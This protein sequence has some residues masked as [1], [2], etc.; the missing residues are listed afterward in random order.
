MISDLLQSLFTGLGLGALYSIVGIGFV[1]IYRVTGVANLTQG[2]LV[3]L[4]AYVMS[5]VA[6]FLP[7]GV[8]ILVSLLVTA[9]AAALVGFAVLTGRALGP[10]AP[11]IMTLGLA[12]AFQGIFILVWGDLPV[13]Y[14]ALI[15][16]AFK[17]GGAFVL[18]QQLLLLG[19]VLVLFILLQVFFSKSY[20]GK[21]LT[22]ASLNPHAAQLVGVELLKMGTIAFAVSGAVAGLAGA[23]FGA[24]VPMTPEA[25]IA[26][27][28]PGF[29]A[30]VIGN[31][32]SP[33][34]AMIGGL[35]LGQVTSAVAVFGLP[36]YQQAAAL[37]VLILVL[38]VRAALVRR[39]GELA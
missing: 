15:T 39:G 9:V 8:A 13:S 25:H 2:A 23:I 7:W 10:H 6:G 20:L 34:G 19:V 36:E 32:H 1:I 37:A 5:S 16:K 21:A 17:V 4:G 26:I 14:P 29:A 11:L 24:L 18:P 22:A 35:L 33:V 30:A 12:I 3:A 28:I 38:L 27:A 31:M